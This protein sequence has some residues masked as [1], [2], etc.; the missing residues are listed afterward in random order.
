MACFNCKGIINSLCMADSRG[1]SCSICGNRN[2]FPNEMNQLPI[3]MNPGLSDI[4]YIIPQ[5]GIRKPTIFVYI[6]DLAIDEEE[7]ASLVENLLISIDLLPANSMISLITY[8]KHVNVHE[9]GYQGSNYSYTFNGT[10][11]YSREEIS[12]K[13]GILRKNVDGLKNATTS[14]IANRFFQQTAI[15]E[16]SLTGLIESLQKDAFKVPQFHR[17]ERATGCAINVAFHMLSTLYPK[18]GARIMLFTGGGCTIG[19]GSIVSTSLKDPIRSH[20]DLSKDAKTIKKFKANTKFYND[21]AEKAS[22]NGH[23][24]DIFIGCYDQVGLSEMECLVGKTGGVIVQSDSFTSAIFKQSLNKFLSPNEYGES[25]FGLNATLEVKCKN[26]KVRGLIGHATALH[27]NNG[28]N[29][30]GGNNRFSFHTEEKGKKIGLS[31]TNC[32]KLG[33]VSTHSSYAVY[34]GMVDHPVGDYSV[35]QFITSYQH[36]DGTQH[37]HVTTSQRFMNQGSDSMDSIISNFDQEAAT[38]IIARQAIDTVANDSSINAL[39]FINKILIDFL[40]IFAKYRVNDTRSV[41]IPPTVNLLP[42]FIYHLRRSNFIQIF[43]SSP[44]ETSFYRHCFLTEDCLNTLIMI[45]PTLTAY[46]LE[47]DSEPVLL[48]ST[49]LK[50]N[51][52][53]F[54][55]TF[56]H[57]LIFHGSLI[58]DWRRQGYQDQPDYEYFK[59]FLELPRQEAADIL[60]D[61]FPLPRFIDT[62]EGGSQARFLMSKLNPTTSYNS[63]DSLEQLAKF[64]PQDGEGAVIMTDDISLQTFMQYVYEAVVKPT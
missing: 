43:N 1:W 64:G 26:V 46:E 39:T 17:K 7:L 55:D 16:F 33:S 44:D 35:I 23:T 24:F 3:E 60:V 41:V 31:G 53:L 36:P 18:I 14:Q 52:I 10:R 2:Q 38:A 63:S 51:R 40:S 9:I 37:I 32:W 6:V 57:I 8:S 5:Q 13:L 62:E 50:P 20:H 12:K 34:F 11:D 61:R 56:F 59:E 45:Q 4:E 29:S 15:C 58:A 30:D 22:I 27:L 49:S 21:I 42:Q 28:K 54:L 19:P 47:K 48:D 25:Q